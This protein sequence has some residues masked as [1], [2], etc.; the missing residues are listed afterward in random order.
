MADVEKQ[1]QV[2]VTAVNQLSDK[3]GYILDAT[4]V[5]LSQGLKVSQDQQ[6]ILIPQPSGNPQDPLNWSQGRK[7]LILFIVSATALLADY[8][9]ATGAV[10]LIPQA[11]YV[12]QS[13]RLCAQTVLLLT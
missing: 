11:A 5:D 7:N 4:K 10:T 8:G 6:T 2:K 12:S 13:V 3:D 1:E 9:S